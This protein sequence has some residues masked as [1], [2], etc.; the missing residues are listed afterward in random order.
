MPTRKAEATWQ[1]N[2]KEGRGTM[3]VDSGAFEGKY[4]FR[5]RFEEEPGTNPEELIGAAHAGCFSMALSNILAE[6]GH[7]PDRVQTTAQVHLETTD[8]GPAI[9]RID[10]HTEAGVP[11]LDEQ[12]FQE[13]AEAA[14]QGCPVSKVLA[15]AEI[16]LDAT[17]T[18][19]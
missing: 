10:L 14:K 12:A 19:S 13:H 5:T 17:L 3:R 8:D 9:T 7:T 2:L 1:G 16:S 15:G 18:S 4:S 6:A 11:G